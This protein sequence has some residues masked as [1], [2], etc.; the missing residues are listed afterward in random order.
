MQDDLKFEISNL[1]FEIRN[2]YP[3]SP[4]EKH[5]QGCILTMKK[6]ESGQKRNSSF[7]KMP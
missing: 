7:R 4:G 2:K 5:A 6:D 1:R 3:A